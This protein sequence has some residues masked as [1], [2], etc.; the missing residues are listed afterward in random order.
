MA[1]LAAA[2]GCASLEVHSLPAPGADL[3]GQ[4][5][6]RVVDRPIPMDSLKP[7]AATNGNGHAN[8]IAHG[9]VIEEPVQDLMLNNTIIDRIVREEINQAFA[10]RGYLPTAADPDFEVF[11][12]T[13][14]Q[15]RLDLEGW[16]DTYGYGYGYGACCY[17]D[18]ETE[19]MIVIDVVD[20]KT[21]QLLWRGG[22]EARVSDNP[23][24]YAKKL[25]KAIEE[26]VERFPMARGAVPATAEDE[27]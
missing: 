2:A 9:A 14:A 1:G 18:D 6:F 4:S 17:I 8:G 19:G 23:D 5:T 3:G 13:K 15:E 16:Y 27:F 26:I 21:K 12:S 20:A 25:A 10:S 24:K 7:E 11:F 22:G